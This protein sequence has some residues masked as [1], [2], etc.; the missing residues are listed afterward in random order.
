[1][2]S[3]SLLVTDRSPE[4]AEHINS[5]LRNSGIK[6]HVFHAATSVEI[7]RALDADL[8]VLILYADPDETDAPLEEV[9]ELAA[10]FSVPVA[11]FTDLKDPE[12]MVRYLS[13][14][15]CVVINSEDE[16]LL[17]RAV[18]RLVKSGESER[19]YELRQSYLEEL[20]H[21]YNLL[22]DSSRDAIAYVHEGLH[23]YANRAYLEAL[24][25]KSADDVAGLSLLE[26]LEAPNQDLKALFRGFSKGSFPADALPVSVRR[27]DG[28][29]FEASLV[30]SPARF[31]GEECIQ[32]MMQRKDAANELAAELERVRMLDPVTQLHN[33]RAFLEEVEVC[34]TAAGGNGTAAILYIEPDGFDRLQEELSADALDAFITDLASVVRTCLQEGDLPARISDRGLAVLAQRATTSELEQLAEKIIGTYRSHIVEI[35]D[36]AMSAS[37]SIGLSN[38]NRMGVNSGEI[39]SHARKAQAEAAEAGDQLVVYRPKLTAV[40]SV[41]GDQIWIDR[42]RHAL[43]DRGFY[44]VQQSI[45]DLDGEGEQLHEN[46]TYL[47]SDS[48]DYPPSEYLETAEENDLAGAIDRAVI[49]GIL[50]T[51]VESDGRHL[52]S[53]SSNSLL[54]YAF[55]GWLSEQM[56]SCCVEGRQLV[57]QISAQAAQSN[58]RPAQRLMKELK[59]LGCELTVSHVDDERKARQLLPHLDASFIKLHPALTRD[60]TSNTKSQELIAKIVEAAEANKV[61]V[62][63]EE[64]ADTSSLAVL[65]Q[66]GVKLISGAFLKESTQVLAQ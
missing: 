30:F 6:I 58:L 55:P 32:M 26:I 22:L 33:R 47:S 56:K 50:K 4:C 54:D 1:M 21:R 65:W 42:I 24:H 63:A 40:S 14:T 2:H 11:L 8:P 61:A 62:I 60:L 16:S 35:D 29:E 41:D 38:F 31:D 64:V 28:T 17:T 59:P 13:K 45:V 25:V 7:K 10:A 19:D 37:C 23:V 49:P 20:E 43:S 18:E 66:C 44:S 57:L 15:A 51:M 5:L 48:N 9:S 34:I 39:I 12:K 3:V 27:P 36:R 52:V 53:L 46:L